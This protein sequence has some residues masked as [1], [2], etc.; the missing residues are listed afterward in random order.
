MPGLGS[1]KFKRTA[2]IRD[3]T[4]TSYERYAANATWKHGREEILRFGIGY[5]VIRANK[6]LLI[7]ECPR[8]LHKSSAVTLKKQHFATL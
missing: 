2:L 5:Y 6:L 7:A 1:R 3:N 4:V 8:Q